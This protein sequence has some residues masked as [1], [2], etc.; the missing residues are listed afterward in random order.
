MTIA[1]KLHPRYVTDTKRRQ[2]AVIIPIAEYNELLED[3]EDLA[4]AAERADETTIPHAQVVKELKA[5][6]YLPGD[7]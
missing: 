4:A 2:T 3:L 6:G 7:L 5:D 1:C